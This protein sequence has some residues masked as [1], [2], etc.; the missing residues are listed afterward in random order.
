MS[1]PDNPHLG[2]SGHKFGYAGRRC[3]LLG[4]VGANL[5]IWVGGVEKVRGSGGGVWIK[6]SGAESV[7]DG[8]GPGLDPQFLQDASHMVLD[9]VLADG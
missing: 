2:K 1:T 6:P 8:F 9:G 4:W 3:C 7:G 5:P